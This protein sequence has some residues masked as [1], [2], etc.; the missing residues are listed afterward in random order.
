MNPLARYAFAALVVLAPAGFAQKWEVG[1]VTGGGFNNNLSV[2]NP[3]GNATTGFANGF[4]FGAI[5]GQNLYPMVSG[6]MH[7]TYRFGDLKVSSAGESATFKGLSHTMHYD[8]LVH[9]RP[10]RARLRPFVAAG[11]GF[12][13][14][15]GVGAESPYQPLSS[16]ALLTKTQQWMPMVTFGGGIKYSISRRVLLRAEVRDYFTSFP[17][18]VIAPAPGAHLSG[19]L[20]DIVPLAGITFVF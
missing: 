9:S 5:L 1:G 10:A 16:F 15:R 14:F 18:K 3:A 4:A 8:I 13:V 7:Y 19:W 6:E 2:S 20:H 11:G 17:T 12:R